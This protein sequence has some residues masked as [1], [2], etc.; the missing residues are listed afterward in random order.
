MIF[1][2]LLVMGVFHSFCSSPKGGCATDNMETMPMPVGDT[3]LTNLAGYLAEGLLEDIPSPS[4]DCP[5]DKGLNDEELPNDTKSEIEPPN[6]EDP[7]EDPIPPTQISPETPESATLGDGLQVSPMTAQMME[8]KQV[9]II[10]LQ[11][12]EPLVCINS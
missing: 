10:K 1:Y 11:L 3:M 6:E 2:G 7:L 9:G 4:P 8:E 5:Q 12:I